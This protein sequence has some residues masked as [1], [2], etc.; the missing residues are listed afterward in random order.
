MRLQRCFA[1]KGGFNGLLDIARRAYC[2]IIEDIERHIC[3]L[4]EEHG[5]SL[6][7]GHN[8]QRGFHV[9]VIYDTAFVT[10]LCQVV[11]KIV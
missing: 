9:Q 6:R 10:V 7:M 11:G 4:S 5:V 3:R 2:E 1:I 8:S